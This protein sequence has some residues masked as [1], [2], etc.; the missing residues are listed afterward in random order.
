MAYF[1][2]QGDRAPAVT[3]RVPVDESLPRACVIGAG[4][5]GIAAARSAICIMALTAA[6]VLGESFAADSVSLSLS[7][8][9]ASADHR[10][11]THTSTANARCAGRIVRPAR[12]A[13]RVTK[14]DMRCNVSGPARRRGRSATRDASP[15]TRLRTSGNLPHPFTRRVGAHRDNPALT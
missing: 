14:R 10:P 7:H 8:P 2:S 4:S 12:D 3:A 11:A 1:V 5:S 13:V 6:S 15:G 9:Q